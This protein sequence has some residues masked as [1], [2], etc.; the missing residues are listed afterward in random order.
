MLRPKMI[1]PKNSA[2]APFGDSFMKF[3]TRIFAV[4]ALALCLS[5]CALSED[6]VTL[7]YIPPAG[8]ATPVPGAGNVTVAVAVSDDRTQDRDRISVKKNGYGMEMAAIRSTNS[9][10]DLVKS[11]LEQELKTRGFLLGQGD[12]VVQARLLRFYNDYKLGMFSGDAAADVSIMLEVKD[13]S[14]SVVYSRPIQ[15]QGVLSGVQI[16]NG[17][18]AKEALEIGLTNAMTH[19]RADKAFF[20]AL[21]K[22][23][24]KK[25]KPVS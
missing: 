18:N 20:D 6:V 15:V 19:V 24:A 17:S 5:A 23:G 12:A 11:A 14:G 2:D 3:V 25:G 21:V 1:F 16:A 9:P 10:V 4:S 8:A 22:A 13:A 7:N